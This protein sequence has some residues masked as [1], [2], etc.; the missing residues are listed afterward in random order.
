MGGALRMLLAQPSS[1]SIHT[2]SVHAAGQTSGMQD[3]RLAVTLLWAVVALLA[4]ALAGVL[5]YSY[6]HKVGSR[7]GQLDCSCGPC[8]VSGRLQ[9]SSCRLS[10]CAGMMHL[11]QQ[12]C[13]CPCETW[14][15]PAS[16]C[17]PPVSDSCPHKGFH[18]Q[19]NLQYARM[20]MWWRNPGSSSSWWPLQSMFTLRTACPHSADLSHDLPH[21]GPRG[22]VCLCSD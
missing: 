1:L 9:R 5:V 6:G 4:G 20:L 12:A 21:C 18:L 11:R 14:G 7:A 13:D 8:L 15:T 22:I 16:C 17:L 2:L 19:Y 10:I 3:S